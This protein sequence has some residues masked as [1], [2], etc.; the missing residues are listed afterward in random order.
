MNFDKNLLMTYKK[1][2]QTTELER[3]YQ[4]FL[5]L[6]RFLR[7]ELEKELGDYRFQGNIIENGMD[8]SYF[9][10]TNDALK[11]KGLKIAVTF[12]HRNFQFEVWLSGFNRKIQCNY[13]ELLKDTR[14]PFSLTED[15]KRS[16]YILRIPLDQNLDLSDG[17][18]VLSEIKD[19]SLRLLGYM[20][21]VEAT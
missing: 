20:E 7:V 14:Q 3:S 2:I 17:K 18:R 15:P 11:K 19:A 13:Y 5:R 4:E 12:V 16:D 6:F 21:G 9:Q 8:Y 10:F 1:L